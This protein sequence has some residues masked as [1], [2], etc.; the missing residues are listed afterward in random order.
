MVEFATIFRL[1]QL[2]AE[3]EATH[4]NASG[5]MLY[6]VHNVT[7]QSVI[8]GRHELGGGLA[9]RQP[10]SLRFAAPF[11]HRSPTGPPSGRPR[12]ARPDAT[13]LRRYP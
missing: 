6:L 8:S 3:F 4:D 1:Q 10:R 7:E 12:F 11:A 5:V 2:L 13:A 9:A